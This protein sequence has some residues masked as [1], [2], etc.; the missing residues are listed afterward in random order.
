[1]KLTTSVT[2]DVISPEG[3]LQAQQTETLEL[4]DQVDS[5]ETFAHYM[6]LS[7]FAGEHAPL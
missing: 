6:A 7:V 1:M 3:V 5:A 4:D 2:R